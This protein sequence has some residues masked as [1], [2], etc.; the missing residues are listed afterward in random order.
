VTRF[1]HLANGHAAS[2][3]AVVPN[4]EADAPPSSAAT[5]RPVGIPS[6][7]AGRGRP[8]FSDAVWACV[9]LTGALLVDVSMV[10]W[11]VVA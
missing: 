11:V 8:S 10:A 4:G 7:P 9:G 5:P 6:L 2:T 1:I 3:D